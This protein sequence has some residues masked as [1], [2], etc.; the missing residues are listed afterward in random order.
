MPTVSLV[1]DERTDHLVGASPKDNRAYA[2]FLKAARELK[3]GSITFSWKEP[4]SGAYHR[5]HFA[6]LA[7]LFDAQE[8]FEDEDVFRKWLEVG[9]GYAVFAPGTDGQM[10][11]IPKSISY[12]SLDQAEFE[13]IH[14]A[15][16]AFARSAYARAYLWPHLSDSDSWGMVESVMGEFM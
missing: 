15:V 7:R 16:M 14:E 3:K 6:I 9:A 10:V 4:R 8:Q 13:P 5:R 1:R 11:A 12:E 2:K